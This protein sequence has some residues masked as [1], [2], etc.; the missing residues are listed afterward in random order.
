MNVNVGK[1]KMM[2]TDLNDIVEIVNVSAFSVK[3]L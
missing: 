3:N 1:K 2:M